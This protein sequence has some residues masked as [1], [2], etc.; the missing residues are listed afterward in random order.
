MDDKF[1]ELAVNRHAARIAADD[2]DLLAYTS[3]MANTSYRNTYGLSR[4]IPAAV[5]KEIR[6]RCGFGCVICGNAIITYEHIDPPFAIARTHDPKR[7][8][9]LC[10]THQTES[11][12]GLLSKETITS[13]DSNPFCKQKGYARHLFDLGGI[14]PVL[15]VG[16]NTLTE[17]GTHHRIR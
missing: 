14:R 9:L 3:V 5:K 16:S 11:T 13:A 12:K 15:V 2:R 17:C 4:Y 6:R 8:T 1:L 7:M 10:G